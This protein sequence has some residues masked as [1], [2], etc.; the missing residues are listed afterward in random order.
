MMSTEFV[1]MTESDLPTVVIAAIAQ[2]LFVTGWSFTRWWVSPTGR[3]FYFKS[4]TLALW[5]DTS[6]ISYYFDWPNET[7]TKI[8]I[9]RVLTLGI[10]VQAIAFFWRRHKIKQELVLETYE[11][12]HV[13]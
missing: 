11:R 12:P 13:S 6:V 1:G 5:L 3:A 2:T 4:L 7:M 10:I 8:I 9:Y